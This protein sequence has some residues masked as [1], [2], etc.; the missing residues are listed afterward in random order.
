MTERKKYAIYNINKHMY[1]KSTV[2]AYI[3]LKTSEHKKC[4]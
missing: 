4:I 3:K 1:T 2:C